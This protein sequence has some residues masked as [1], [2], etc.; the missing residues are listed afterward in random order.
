M[1]PTE[2]VWH[3]LREYILCSCVWHTYDDIVEACSTAWR[4]LIDDLLR[5]RSIGH[6]SWACVSL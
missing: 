3:Y 4:F 5:I 1:N 6:R 2:N